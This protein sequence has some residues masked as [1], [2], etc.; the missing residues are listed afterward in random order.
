VPCFLH[1]N[2]LPYSISVAA[3][4]RPQVAAA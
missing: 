2:I 4:G 3:T 1:T